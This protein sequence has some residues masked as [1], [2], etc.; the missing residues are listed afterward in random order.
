MGR[1][2]NDGEF[3]DM[4]VLLHQAGDAVQSEAG[5]EAVDEMGERSIVVGVTESVL[6]ES[7]SYAPAL[8]KPALHRL[9]ALRDQCGETH[10]VEAEAGIAGLS[11]HGQAVG[12]QVRDAD[13]IAHRCAGTDL[14][15]VDLVVGAEQRDLQKSRAV[16]A[17]LHGG[18]KLGGE[19]HD[20]AEHVAFK[21]DRIGESLLGHIGRH[22]PSRRDRLVFPP[23][24]LIEAADKDFAEPG[25]E[26][27]AR[28]VNDIGDALEAELGERLD[29]F[30]RKPQGRHR[31]R[32]EGVANPARRHQ[33]RAAEMRDREGAADRIGDGGAGVQTLGGEARKDVAAHGGFPTEQMGTAGDVEHEAVRCIEADQRRVTVAPVGDGVDEAPIRF[34]VGLGDRKRRIHGARVGERHAEPQAETLRGV[35]HGHDAQRALDQ[36]GDDQRLTRRACGAVREATGCEATRCEAIRREPPE[37]Q[38]EIAMPQRRTHDD[39]TTSA[40]GRCDRGGF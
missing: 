1:Q 13:R 28:Q 3:R 11:D 15:A 18:A 25:G 23:E 36:A 39:P 37:P 7:V 27:C 21:A 16:L 32:H 35:V 38:G 12:K 24:R 17:P 4:G 6:Q 40:T 2:G 29:G 5:A 20:G 19:P 9:A 22:R 8:R 14:D 30:G 10:H 34:L 31:Q 26:R 33:G